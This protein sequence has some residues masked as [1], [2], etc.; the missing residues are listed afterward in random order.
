[1]A[2]MTTKALV[3]GT[4]AAGCLAAALGGF[5]AQRAGVVQAEHEA[6]SGTEVP[7]EPAAPTG[8]EPEPPDAA[9][10]SPGTPRRTVTP[11]R[12]PAAP[13]DLPT[14][15]TPRSGR[16]R[17]EPGASSPPPPPPPPPPA[18]ENWPQATV[19]PPR[20]PVDPP[21]PTIGP[22][23][24]F[25]P[26]STPVEP[27]AGQSPEVVAAEPARF[28]ELTIDEDTVIGI[29]LEGAV[30]TEDARVEDRV[31]ARVIRD[32]S[33]EDRTAIPAGALLEGHV[34]LVEQGG[35]FR[36]RARLGVRFSRLVLSDETV[37]R[38]QTEPIYRD[39][40]SPTGEATSKI[41]ASAVI[42]AVLGGVFGGRKGAA[43]G[44]T[45]GAAGGSAAVA[46]GGPNAATLAEGTALTVR[47][48]EPVTLL[49][50]RNAPER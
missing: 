28:I 41:G 42:G 14:V 50:E 19:E 22:P 13:V 2:A 12:Q 34:V 29:R 9:R 6:V 20:P 18:P 49:V 1:M 4:V 30:T 40:E 43:I 8:T 45:A 3:I 11:E 46:A 35:R 37:V 33:A 7:V 10:E 32:V 38:I 48:I 39:G 16:I 36:D 25:E 26:P 17:G 47:L 44:G 15:A 24:A 5:V 23:L 31:T 27:V 21:A